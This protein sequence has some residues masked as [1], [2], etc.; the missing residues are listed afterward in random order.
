M[1]DKNHQN[2]QQITK[3]DTEQVNLNNKETNTHQNQNNLIKTRSGISMRS[4]RS[5]HKNN[6]TNSINKTSASLENKTTTTISQIPQKFLVK[7]SKEVFL[8]NKLD[9]KK[10]KQKLFKEVENNKKSIFSKDLKEENNNSTSKNNISN[11]NNNEVSKTKSKKKMDSKTITKEGLR[12]VKYEELS[13]KYINENYSIRTLSIINRIIKKHYISFSLNNDFPLHTI[14]LKLCRYLLLNEIEL[15]V[16]SIYLDRFGWKNNYFDINQ[17]IFILGILTKIKVSPDSGII[18]PAVYN[19]IPG[20]ENAYKEFISLKIEN[21]KFD[22]LEIMIIDINKRYVELSTP[23]NTH[24]KENFM[25]YNFCVD[26]ILSMSLPYSD[27]KK[28][29]T[30]N[31]INTI[32]VPPSF[33]DNNNNPHNSNKREYMSGN[34]IAPFSNDN[35]Y[36][37]NNNNMQTIGVPFN[38]SNMS[39]NMLHQRNNISNPNSYYSNSFNFQQSNFNSNMNVL[40]NLNNIRN[41]SNNNNDNNNYYN[42]SNNSMASSNMNSANNVNNLNNNQN[43]KKD[44]T[45]KFKVQADNKEESVFSRKEKI[46]LM[47]KENPFASNANSLNTKNNN[48]I[49]S[50]NSIVTSNNKSNQDLQ[51][52]EQNNTEDTNTNNKSNALNIKLIDTSNILKQANNLLL[53]QYSYNNNN[54]N[55]NYSDPRGYY[56]S[57][58][59]LK[60]M[61]SNVNN[62]F[63]TLNQLNYSMFQ[64]S[65]DN[66]YGNY[67]SLSHVNSN[68]FTA[69]NYLNQ[70]RT[71]D[72]D[73]N[74]SKKAS[75]NSFVPTSNNKFINQQSDFSINNL[76]MFPP[77]PLE[78][79][80]SFLNNGQHD[81]LM[82]KLNLI[83]YNLISLSEYSYITYYLSV[84]KEIVV[85]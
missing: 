18:V 57:D 41:L 2:N 1:N 74:L 79:K 33:K 4:L 78:T 43:N 9:M 37:N 67:P 20:L 16:L 36:N 3:P 82:S 13:K 12:D 65:Y 39:L 66:N 28:S 47:L 29:N 23:F 17:Y 64:N 25:D 61:F 19:E 22:V 40:S 34:P 42:I 8:V 85:I 46:D 56:N 76:T 26:Q 31:F 24:C 59:N 15:S 30:K 5:A 55:Y 11:G 63:P 6:N 75:N 35:F 70:K 50:E 81:T 54:N 58:L 14:M 10:V 21:E 77:I 69:N 7:E 83:I 48:N 60:N 68:V 38:N 27:N 80:F 53:N 52:K 32:S 49:K 44:K 73:I 51:L 62:A 72:D 84:I 45:T 71:R